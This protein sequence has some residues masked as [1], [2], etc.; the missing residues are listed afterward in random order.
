MLVAKPFERGPTAKSTRA[1]LYGD[2]CDEYV[3]CFRHLEAQSTFTS[4]LYSLQSCISAF[5]S[6]HWRVCSTCQIEIVLQC[7]LFFFS[8]ISL[9]KPER[10]R[11][12]SSQMKNIIT[13]GVERSIAPTMVPAKFHWQEMC[14]INHISF[15]I[16]MYVTCIPAKQ[17]GGTTLFFRTVQ[18]M[19]K[20]L[21]DP[22]HYRDDHMTNDRFQRCVVR[23]TEEPA[24]RRY[25]R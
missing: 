22:F 4:Q 9:R 17:S 2:E 18:H 14:G 24:Y 8:T 1:D 10:R 20:E 12:T 11:P 5:A 6:R 15:Q 16:F 7:F 25:S 13:V 23:M 21:T 3:E 19:T